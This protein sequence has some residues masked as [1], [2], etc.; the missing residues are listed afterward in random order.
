M[1][2]LYVAVS[3][4]GASLLFQAGNPGVIVFFC[5]SEKEKEF[6]P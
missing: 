4:L 6:Y 2:V 5:V 3:G 1:T